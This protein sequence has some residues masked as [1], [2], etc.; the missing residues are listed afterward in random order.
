MSINH[1]DISEYYK[2]INE[3]IDKY[4]G[5][6]KIT[7]SKLKKYLKEGTKRYE[8]FIKRNKLSNIPNIKTILNDVISDRNNMEKDGVLTFE[9]FIISENKETDKKISLKDILYKGIE[10]S[11]IKTEKA[12]ADYF[13]T[14]LGD[15]DVINSEKHLFSVDNW[16][17]SNIKVIVFTKEDISIIKENFKEY[18]Y[19]KLLNNKI[20]IHDNFDV[21]LT[22]LVDNE[23]FD[24][25]IEPKLDKDGI[26]SLITESLENFKY[27]GSSGNYLFWSSK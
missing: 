4:I 7:P 5:D 19:N 2:M 20:N 16:K 1:K 18:F 8:N 25:K 3:L 26:I 17:D 10:R 22:G 23:K 6:H 14:N 11:D 13:D 15:I 12:I 21:D 9:S 27:L 24:K